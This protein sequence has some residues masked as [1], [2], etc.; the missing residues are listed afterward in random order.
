[1]KRTLLL[2]AGFISSVSFAQVERVT[3]VETFTSSTCPPCNPG[4][5]NLEGILANSVNDGKYASIKYQMS[6][7]GTGDPYFTNEGDIRRGYYSVTSVPYT[8][9]DAGYNGNPSSLTQTHFNNAYA[10]P[11]KADI[12]AWYQIDEPNQTVNVQVDFETFQDLYPGSRLF[13]GI[14]E[15]VTDNNVKTNGE[16]EFYHVM[17]KLVPSAA[18]KVLS[19]MT[20]GQMV[21]YD[22]TF[23]FQGSYRLPGDATDPIDNAIEH[24][25]EEFSDLGVV[26]W[27]QHPN[28]HEVYQAAN[29]VMGL[30]GL[31]EQ[32]ENIA[33]SKVYPNPLNDNGVLVFHLLN[34]SD[35]S[36]QIVN[37]QGQ[38]ILTDELNGLETGRIEYPFDLNGLGKGM[39][40]IRVVS[41]SDVLTERVTK[42]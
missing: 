29:A 31:V 17:K 3:L 12:H 8:A 28:S 5:I 37:A 33:S 1:M 9:L 42:L 32:P 34:S 21:H 14:Y 36:I 11:P 13:V 35:V 4:N 26:V 24:S 38:V 2:L 15:N 23:E 41:G 39:Y 7:P 40:S 10:V 16:T 19:A 6:W 20:A 25:V 18:G 30:A 27:A 22:F